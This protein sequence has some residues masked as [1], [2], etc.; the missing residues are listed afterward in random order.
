MIIRLKQCNNNILLF[1]ILYLIDEDE[2]HNNPN[3]HSEEQDESEIPD[4]TDE[5]YKL[6]NIIIP[7][8][9]CLLKLFKHYDL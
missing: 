5:L 8:F 2:V 1:L 3:L 6:D 4:N 7:D 9:F